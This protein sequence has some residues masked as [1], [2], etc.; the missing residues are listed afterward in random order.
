MTTADAELAFCAHGIPAERCPDCRPTPTRSA[1]SRATREAERRRVQAAG[2]RRE[3]WHHM[4]LRCSGHKGSV[5]ADLIEH[6][7]C[8][9]EDQ[10]R[11][12]ID[13]LCECHDPEEDDR[14]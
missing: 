3:M 4:S 1:L 9:A 12:R 14:G 13:C 8:R 6:W 11:E 7:R 5:P 10:R 2:A